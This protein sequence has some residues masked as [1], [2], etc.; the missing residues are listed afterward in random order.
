[1]SFYWV[2][3]FNILQSQVEAIY[4]SEQSTEKFHSVQGGARAN[5]SNLFRKI[6]NNKFN[7]NN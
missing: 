4:D 1:M 3:S 5:F 2:F 7:I 6:E